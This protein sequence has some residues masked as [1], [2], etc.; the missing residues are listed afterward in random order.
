MQPGDEQ[1]DEARA[2]AVTS[3]LHASH[4]ASR[5]EVPGRIRSRLT[6]RTGSTGCQVRTRGQGVDVD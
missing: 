2:V 3:V 6:I 4:L 1:V 5:R